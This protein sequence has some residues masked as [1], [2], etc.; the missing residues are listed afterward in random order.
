MPNDTTTDNLQQTIRQ[1]LN[2]NP[3]MAAEV[4][5]HAAELG[6]T[7]QEL[8]RNIMR[9][10]ISKCCRA[11]EKSPHIQLLMRTHHCDV[12]DAIQLAMDNDDANTIA[13]VRLALFRA[14]LLPQADYQRLM[15]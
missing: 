4:E 11:V 15:S 13:S 3:E 1:V 5:R 2:D 7:P 8:L 14:G 10:Y 6:L 9:D 12:V